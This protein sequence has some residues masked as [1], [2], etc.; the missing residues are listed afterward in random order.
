MYPEGNFLLKV[1]PG[2]K[3]SRHPRLRVVVMTLAEGVAMLEP[4]QAPPHC[5]VPPESLAGEFER[6]QIKVELWFGR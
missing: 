5:W 3:E 6:A 2:Q 1:L 4:D